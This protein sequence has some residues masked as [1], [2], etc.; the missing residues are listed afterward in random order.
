MYDRYDRMCIICWINFVYSF[1]ARTSASQGIILVRGWRTDLYMTKPP[2]KSTMNLLIERYLKVFRSVP[3][4][5]ALYTCDS[6]KAL[7]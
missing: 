4:F 6:Q 5:V 2:Q 7:D 1:M 3:S